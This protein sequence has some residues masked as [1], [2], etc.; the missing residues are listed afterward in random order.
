MSPAATS[1]VYVGEVLHA[2]REPVEHAFRYPHW[3][4]A[5]ALDELDAL[6]EKIPA[7]LLGVNRPGLVSVHEADYLGGGAGPLRE[8]LRARVSDLGGDLPE[9]RVVLVTT[10]RI[11]GH[12]F[13]PVSFY[14]CH[15]R[16]GRL[17]LM[18]AEVN[19]T[20]GEGHLYLVDAPDNPSSQPRAFHVSPFN[21][22]ADDY[23][24]TVA[25]LGD[26][27]D[28]SIDIVRAG[29]DPQ[30]GEW[31][32]SRLRGS[33]VPLTARSLAGVLAR[34]PLTMALQ[35]PRILYQAG[36]LHLKKGLAHHPKP[37]PSSPATFASARPPYLKDFRLPEPIAR[38]FG[39]A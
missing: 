10:P 33:W 37:T 4:L 2:R 19:N 1:G 3:V 34:Y 30:R 31:F 16:E 20:F 25:P 13:N 28:V 9:G 14:F 22:I 36:V 27:L 8:R 39:A 18:V 12:T 38:A 11:L 24:F 35:L 29:D 7:A 17:E 32:T 6:A 5:L 21:A 26:T 15:G 23:R